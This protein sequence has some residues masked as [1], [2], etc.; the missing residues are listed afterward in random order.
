MIESGFVFTQISTANLDLHTKGLG[1]ARN[2]PKRLGLIMDFMFFV[3]FFVF[4]SMFF[5]FF[6]F[7]VV[8][9]VWIVFFWR[10]VQIGDTYIKTRRRCN[11]Y[12]GEIF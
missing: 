12:Y 7:F 8:F 1:S 9:R 11:I 2:P 6:V 5:M 3:I 10:F 4:F